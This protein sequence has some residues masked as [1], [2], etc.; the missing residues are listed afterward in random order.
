ML[1]TAIILFVFAAIFG[2]LVLLSVLKNK[3][4]PKPAVFIHGLLAAAGLAIVAWY[5]IENSNNAPMAS[6]IVFLV[7]ALGGFVMFGRDMTNR[8]VPK[9]LA[10]I[11]AGA[12]VVG[13]LLLVLFVIG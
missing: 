3:T 9:G 10:L 5:V 12:A 8:S 6:L 2:L 13:L 7:A 4:T 1:L 11:H